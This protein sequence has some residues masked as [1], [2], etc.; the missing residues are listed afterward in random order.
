MSSVGEGIIHQFRVHLELLRP[1]TLLAPIIVSCSVMIASLVYTGTLTLSFLSLLKTIMIASICFALLNGA[2][3]ILNQATDWKE[4]ALS[5][6]YRPIPR[7]TI[8]PR[9]AYTASLIIYMIA[10]L[11]S[12]AVHLLFCSFICIIAFF[13]ITYSLPPR[14]K[15]YL[16]FNQ[17]W[18]AL[19]RGFFAIL[20]SWS[21]FSNPFTPLPLAMGCIAALFLFG[22][23]ATKDILDA[24]ADKTVGTKTLINVY[25]VKRTAFISLFFMLGAFCLVGPLVYLGIIDDVFLPIMLLGFLSI[26]IAWLMFYNQKNTRRENIS[27]WTLMYVT[28]FIFAVSFSALTISFFA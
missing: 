23:T 3:N 19:P 8:T 6:P 2:S 20:A 12:L 22:G 18:V 10:L 27:A 15:K 4:D 9:E 7:G 16:L 14:I 5:K 21:V 24:E 28:Y 13:S 17:L 25:G 11:L 26:L 1:F